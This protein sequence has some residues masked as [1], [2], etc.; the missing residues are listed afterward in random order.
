MIL[1]AGDMAS[2]H[3]S[4]GPLALAPRLDTACW[5]P[6]GRLASAHSG[7]CVKRSPGA[8]RHC[9]RWVPDPQWHVS[10]TRTAPSYLP[11]TDRH[12]AVALRPAPRRDVPTEYCR[13][14]L[15]GV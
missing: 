13:V 8:L 10:P 4:A 9:C 11:I 15:P 2:A 3:N 1:L 12:R 6:A 14:W 7:P 5:C